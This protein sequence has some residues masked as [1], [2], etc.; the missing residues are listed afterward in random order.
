LL[1]QSGYLT[2]KSIQKQPFGNP[3]VYILG[4]PN[5]EVKLSMLECLVSS[6]AEYPVAN[7]GTMR[8]S[9]E[10]DLFEGNAERF[11]SKVKELFAN[12]PHQLH[13]PQEAYY[14]SLLLVWLKMLGFDVQGE[15]STSIGRIDAVLTLENQIIVA[16][17]KYAKSGSTEALLKKAFKQI[18]DNKY[19]DSFIA[20]GKAISLLAIGFAGRKIACRFANFETPIISPP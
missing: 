4:I 12:I 5:E 15:Y 7:M 3:S 13:I 17:V 20:S 6:Y 19:A 9:M 8:N 1:F 11:E 18:Y 10:K 14:H 2:I 16:E